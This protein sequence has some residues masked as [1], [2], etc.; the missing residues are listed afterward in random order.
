MKK[1]VKPTG[2][3]AFKLIDARIISLLASLYL[4]G[5]VTPKYDPPNSELGT[6]GE[7]SSFGPNI[8]IGAAAVLVDKATAVTLRLTIGQV[9]GCSRPTPYGD[10]Q[11]H[12]IESSSKKQVSVEGVKA[13]EFTMDLRLP[14][15][16]YSIQLWDD[17]LARKLGSA[18]LDI[19]SHDMSLTL[20]DTCPEH[21]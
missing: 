19:N 12:L 10:M 18:D 17:R 8:A 16:S 3:A 13:R 11:V 21:R 1:T 5:C 15:G 14:L 7:G 6:Q 9:Q 2:D 4:T 20:F